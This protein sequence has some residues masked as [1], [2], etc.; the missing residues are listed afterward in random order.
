MVSLFEAPR[1]SRQVS[2]DTHRPTSSICKDDVCKNYSPE[3]PLELRDLIATEPRNSIKNIVTSIVQRAIES[4]VRL[5][6]TVDGLFYHQSEPTRLAHSRLKANTQNQPIIVVGNGPSLKQTPLEEFSDTFAI[7][8]NKIHLLYSSTRWR[9]SLIVCV[10]NLVARQNRAVFATS[11]IPVFLA[12]KCRWF[13]GRNNNPDLHYFKNR[14]T[15]EFSTDVSEWAAGLSP[16]VTYTALQFAYYLG[17]NPVI[18][19]GVDHE[20]DTAPDAS[21]IMKKTGPDKNHFDP[22]YFQDGQYWGLPDLEGSEAAYRI[23]RKAF[24]QDGREILDAT[25]GGK[26]QVFRK[27]NLDE[28]RILLNKH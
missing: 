22:D 25:I 17:G 27:I 9:P 4:T 15:M 18:L 8:M 20:F 10:N 13:M 21:G 3:K 19:F 24:E 6:Y 16:T 28:A 7:G 23:A 26:L 14:A 12:W 1:A 11:D 2:P 5:R